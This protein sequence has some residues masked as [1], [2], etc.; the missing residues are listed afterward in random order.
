[1][2]FG[3]A[4]K[5]CL[6]KYVTFSGRAAR[7]EY[8]WFFLFVSTVFAA[9]MIVGGVLASVQ[10]LGHT[11]TPLALVGVCLP[12]A[13]ILVMISPSLA[14]GARRLHDADLSGWWQVLPLGIAIMVGAV[15]PVFLADSRTGQVDAHTTM[16]LSVIVWI[17]QIAIIVL[18]A[19][20]SDPELN[21]FGPP[22]G[23]AI[24]EA[25]YDRSSI[26]SVGGRKPSPG[27]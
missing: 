3:Q 7:S 4:I 22:I 17:A 13:A 15:G 9:L 24:E 16:L 2:T 27:D 6:S 23:L 8:W 1:M 11:P 12:W 14:A 10:P 19:R 26:P 20:P 5:T 18:L 25:E 21:R